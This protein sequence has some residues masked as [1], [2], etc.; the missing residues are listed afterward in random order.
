MPV[1]LYVCMTFHPYV[2]LS[3]RT[4]VCPSIHLFLGLPF[5]ISVFKLHKESWKWSIKKSSH[6]ILIIGTIVMKQ[7]HSTGAFFSRIYLCNHFLL[8]LVIIDVIQSCGFWMLIEIISM[9]NE[10]A[11]YFLF[12]MITWNINCSS[13]YINNQ[14]IQFHIASHPKAYP[15]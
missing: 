3:F 10:I 5:C 1:C 7:K 9:R 4:S 12:I 8:L 14:K 6:T 15:L 11:F 13:N 2:W